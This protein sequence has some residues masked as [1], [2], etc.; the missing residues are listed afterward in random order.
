ME[1]NKIDHFDVEE[2]VQVICNINTEDSSEIEN[3]IYEKYGC[4]FDQ[5]HNIVQDIFDK[6]DFGL[7]PITQE[8]F[9]GIAHN[10]AWLIKKNIDQQFIKGIIE[11]STEGSG[12]EVDSN[13]YERTVTKEGKPEFK[14]LILKPDVKV[15]F[16][17]L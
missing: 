15:K 14:F 8:A 13:G 12:I 7:S 10:N 6:M 11:W 2:I 1:Q 9:I 3:A 4:D 5:Y 17:K 16:D